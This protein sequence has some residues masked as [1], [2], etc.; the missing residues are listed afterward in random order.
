MENQLIEFLI[1]LGG[2]GASTALSFWAWL[3]SEKEGRKNAEKRAQEVADRERELILEHV[4][5]LEGLAEQS[6]EQMKALSAQSKETMEGVNNGQ[7]VIERMEK[8]Q[9]QIHELIRKWIQ[10]YDGAG[11]R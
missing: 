10:H 6:I 8:S 3:K 1:G 11:S 5:T 2:G 9:T 7:V 4:V